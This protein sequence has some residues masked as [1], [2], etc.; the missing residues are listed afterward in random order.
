MISTPIEGF[1]M[2]LN[3][4]TVELIPAVAERRFTKLVITKRGPWSVFVSVDGTNWARVQGAF[5][6]T[7][8]EWT[9]TIDTEVVNR[10]VIAK[11]D[12]NTI[13]S[14]QLDPVHVWAHLT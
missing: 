10:A 3:G 9:L 5:Y 12:P 8:Q 2:P 1:E 6:S 13:S 11:L 7:T 14:Q 4:D